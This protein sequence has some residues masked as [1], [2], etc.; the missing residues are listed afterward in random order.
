MSDE[1]QGDAADELAAWPQIVS[2]ILAIV[3]GVPSL[4][5]VVVGFIHPDPLSWVVTATL[6]AVSVLLAVLWYRAPT[7]ERAILT[8]LGRR[9]MPPM[10]GYGVPLVLTSAITV[11]ALI[12]ASASVAAFGTVLLILKT[13]EGWNAWLAKREIGKGIERALGA[14]QVPEELRDNTS[15]EDWKSQVEAVYTFYFEHPWDAV[16][17]TEMFVVA[18]ATILGAWLLAGGDVASMYP[19]LRDAGL[20]AATLMIVAAVIGNEIVALIWRRQRDRAVQAP[21]LREIERM[22]TK[23]IE[24]YRR[25]RAQAST[26]KPTSSKQSRKRTSKPS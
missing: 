1:Y 22:P 6:L 18:M 24:K 17:I 4:M 26:R 3:L 19:L 20:V 2:V 25:E 15:L 5:G 7:Q 13:F 9:F 16:E 12:V 11:I 23:T 14:S 8:M 10:P 21:R